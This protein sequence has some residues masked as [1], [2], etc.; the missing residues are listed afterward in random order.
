LTRQD[1]FERRVKIFW[2]IIIC[3]LLVLL[4][5]IAWLQLIEGERY[6]RISKN[7]RLRLIPLPCARGLILDRNGEKLAGNEAFFSVGVVPSNVTDIDEL[8]KCLNE[9]LDID[10][11]VAKKRIQ[12]ANNIFRPVWV[13]RNID[14]SAVTYLLEK[15]EDFAGTVILTEPV[16]SYYYDEMCAHVLGHV[17]EVNQEELTANSAFGVEL[18][19][20]V[21]KMGVEKA[22]NSYLQGAKGGRQVEVDAHGRTLRVISEKD[23]LPGDSVYLTIDLEMQKIAE[24]KLGQK[25]GVVLIGDYETGEILTL[26]SHPSFNPNLFSWGVSED[27]WSKLVQDPGDP[28]ENRALRGEYSP[29]STFKI[30]VTAAALEDNIIGKEDTFFCGGELPVGNR[31]FKCWKEE[32]HG[33]MDLEQAI[34]DSCNIFFYQLGLKI[35]MDKIIQYSRLFELGEITGIDLVSEKNGLLP[36]RDWKLKTKGEAWYPGD[37]ANLSIGHGFILVTPVQMLRVIAAVANGGSL[38]DPYLVKEIVDS[39]GKVVDSFSPGRGKKIPISSSI[40]DFLGKSLRGVVREGTGWRA[41][42]KI[43]KIA[44]KTGTAESSDEERPHNWFIGYT[45]PDDARLAIVVLIEH[46]EEEISIA[47]QIAGEI[48]SQIF[49]NKIGTATIF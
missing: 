49:N 28:L 32:G 48:L 38:I 20:L 8:I 43:V 10:K 29:A 46:R 33:S 23:P 17:G 21:G 11:E 6:F 12:E 35:G 7:S 40:F 9:F 30:I 14:L 25:K 3:G 19:D 1:Q 27:E 4:G 44:G 16:R 24:E 42:N 26:V 13:K 18:G 39:Q 15:E 2:I 22:Y 36:T 37:T 34:I 5:R 45:L 41:E 31:I 47:A